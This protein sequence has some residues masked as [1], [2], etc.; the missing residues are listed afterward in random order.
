MRAQWVMSLFIEGQVNLAA[1]CLRVVLPLLCAALCTVSNIFLRSDFGMYG[2][3][4]S[5]ETSQ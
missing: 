4:R 2:L 5:V 1:M 3:I